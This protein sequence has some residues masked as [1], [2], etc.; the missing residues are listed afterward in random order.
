MHLTTI[1]DPWAATGPTGVTLSA[2]FFNIASCPKQI[3]LPDFIQGFDDTQMT[4]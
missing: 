3:D 4:S 2:P 1:P